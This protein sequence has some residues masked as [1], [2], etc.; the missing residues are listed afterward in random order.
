MLSDVQRLKSI[1]RRKRKGPL[2]WYSDKQ[3]LEAVQVWLMCGSMVQTAA[4]LGIPEPTIEKWKYT[5]WWKELADQIKAEGR[6]KLSGRLQKIVGKSL[7]QLEDRIE[8]GDWVI[9]SKTGVVERKPLLAR[10]LTRISTEFMD[11]NRKLESVTREEATQQA[12]EDRL[13]LLADSF[14]SFAK[15]IRRV[16]VED[17]DA[18]D[19]RAPI[20]WEESEV[21]LAEQAGDPE[22][23]EIDPEGRIHD[24]PS[25]EEVNGDLG[26][27]HVEVG[28]CDVPEAEAEGGSEQVHPNPGN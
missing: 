11:S 16:D 24:Q 15:K 20:T 28:E 5:D 10:D 1:E 27:D 25:N 21:R 23:G 12:V 13:K 4:A 19:R 8:N 14:A 7:D 2:G 18:E 3:K 9:N 22:G 26:R 17:I 6:V